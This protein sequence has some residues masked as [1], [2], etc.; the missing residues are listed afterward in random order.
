MKKDIRVYLAQRSERIDRIEA[1]VKGGREVFFSELMI[2]DAVISNFEVMGEAAK[3]VPEDYRTSHP[4]IPW[5]S[6][7][8]FKDVHIHQYGGVSF[9]QVWQIIA[10]DLPDLKRAT[11]AVL[12]PLDELERELNHDD[13]QQ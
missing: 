7:A 12:P 5:R 1:C 9:A 8:A 11:T 6:L 2:R 13:T 10:Y 4:E 3:R